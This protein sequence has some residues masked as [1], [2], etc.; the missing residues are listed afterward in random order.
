MNKNLQNELEQKLRKE[1]T[2]LE[3]DLAQ[4]AERDPQNPENWDAKFP[5]LNDSGASYSD[6]ALEE[7]AEEITEYET[8][9]E[10]EHALEKR[11]KEVNDALKLMDSGTYGVCAKCSKEISEERLAA[12]PAAASHTECE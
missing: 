6:A 2:A 3:R 8:R 5:S 4:F 9:R 1:K 7:S 11:L 12:N 10:E